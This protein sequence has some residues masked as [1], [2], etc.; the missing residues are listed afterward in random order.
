MAAMTSGETQQYSRSTCA[1]KFGTSKTD[2]FSYRRGVWQGCVLSPLLFNLFVNELPLSL[3]QSGTD[4][5]SFRT[6]V[7]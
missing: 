4:H 6:E 5:L 2:T 1:I 3:N 7:N